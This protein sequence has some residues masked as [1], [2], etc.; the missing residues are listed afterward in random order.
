V[1]GYRTTRMS[2]LLVFRVAWV[3]LIA[4]SLSLGE[5]AR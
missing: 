1:S 4:C 2:P 3:A 5:D